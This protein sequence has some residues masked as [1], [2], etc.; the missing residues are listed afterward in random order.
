[1]AAILLQA[2]RPLQRLTRELISEREVQDALLLAAAA[3]V[4][5]SAGLSLLWFNR[6]L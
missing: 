2:K 4:L 3:L 1:M 5:A 6:I